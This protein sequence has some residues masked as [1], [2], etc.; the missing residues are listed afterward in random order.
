MNHARGLIVTILTLAMIVPAG[1][2]AGTAQQANH[3]TVHED[4]PTTLKDGPAP[5][6]LVH[7]R[8]AAPDEVRDGLEATGLAFTMLERVGI[9]QT[10]ATPD[11]L[12]TLTTLPGIHAIY[13]EE[14]L[15]FHLDEAAPLV[16][17]P[18]VWN[19]HGITGEGATVL[20]IDT[21]TDA[22]HLDLIGPIVENAQPHD[23]LETGLVPEG[24]IEGV[25]A[26]DWFGHGTHVAGIVAGTGDATGPL[27]PNHE[28]YVGIAP[29]ADIVSWAIPGLGGD[30]NVFQAVQG[31]E[32][33]LEHQERFGIDVITNSWGMSGEP[34]PDHPIN[35]ASLEAYKA[36]MSVIFSAGNSGEP[37]ADEDDDI[38][39]NMFSTVPWTLSVSALT[40]EPEL[41]SFSS[42]GTQPQE[43]ENLWEHPDIGAQGVSVMAAKSRMGAMQA[44]GPTYEAPADWDLLGQATHYQYASGTSMSAPGV[45]GVLALLYSANP[46]LSPAQA[47][48][49]LIETSQ[50][51]YYA[52][53]QAGA[54][55]ADANAAVEKAQATT[56]ERDA[57]LP[58]RRIT[59]TPTS[60]T[61]SITQRAPS[62]PRKAT[63][64]QALK[65]SS[66]RWT[67]PAPAR[68]RCSINSTKPEAPSPPPACLQASS[69]QASQRSSPADPND[70]KT[71]I[72]PGNWPSA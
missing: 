33:A 37:D 69:S 23:P 35:V 13:P 14:T 10:I 66:T 3:A 1:A 4:V 50:P 45:A 55:L 12:E 40:S 18:T 62:S 65:P 9:T 20:V 47:Y 52:Y 44:L 2:Y 58:L 60:P 46:N 49:I 19:D 7:D 61:P 51:L 26:N 27:D 56:G 30:G 71:Q 5:L 16:N 68:T 57:F 31:F 59:P 17:A 48:D 15:T 32:Y 67:S 64:V 29:G 22:L 25:P 54:G 41:A 21:G 70:R 72:H 38:R 53:W 36:G 11:D 42:Q 24:Y 28:R 63:T 34:D 8:H 6:L 43:R 39:L